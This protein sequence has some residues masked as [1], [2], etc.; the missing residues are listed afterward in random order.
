[1]KLARSA[2]LTSRNGAVAGVTGALDG[3]SSLGQSDSTSAGYDA[4]FV[5]KFAP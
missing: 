5:A 3:T 4:I 2:P 1:M